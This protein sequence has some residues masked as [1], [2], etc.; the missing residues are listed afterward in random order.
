MR[1]TVC[2]TRTM[3]KFQS[4]SSSA[5]RSTR[6]NALVVVVAASVVFLRLLRRRSFVVLDVHEHAPLIPDA[7]SH[8]LVQEPLFHPASTRARFRIQLKRLQ[9]ST[10]ETHVHRAN[11]DVRPHR[12][13]VLARRERLDPEHSQ[14]HRV[15]HAV[16]LVERLI[17]FR[18]AL[19]QN[20]KRIRVRRLLR[21]HQ[22]PSPAQRPRRRGRA[23]FAVV[24]RTALVDRRVDPLGVVSFDRIQQIFL[25]A[26]QLQILRPRRVERARARRLRARV[27]ARPR[28][29]ARAR[30]EPRVDAPTRRTHRARGDLPLIRRT[31]RRHRAERR[32]ATRRAIRGSR[33]RVVRA[34]RAPVP[35]DAR[36][37]RA[38]TN[39]R[40]R[41]AG[42]RSNLN[43]TAA[44]R[45]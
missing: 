45:R 11:L 36:S 9:P 31:A 37:R 22:A 43:E 40:G 27:Q 14:L 32:R 23:S 10:A 21:V 15:P 24:Q 18:R 28:A 33:E 38:T 12:S 1:A 25:R 35:D 42:A 29:S 41:R 17:V 3:I 7:N 26:E 39:D 44:R 13:R 4:S 6:A 5:R 16:V 19:K 30:R 20:L 8:F 34:R 2:I